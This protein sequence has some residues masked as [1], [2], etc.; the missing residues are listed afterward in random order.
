V[1]EAA[2][3]QTRMFVTLLQGRED[4][5]RSAAEE[6]AQLAA[7]IREGAEGALADA[8]LAMLEPG[9]EPARDALAAA[10]E[11][12]RLLDDK[13]ALAWVLNRGAQR[14]RLSGRPE[15][16]ARLAGEALEKAQ[17][18]EARSEAAIA[19]MSPE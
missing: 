4:E 10:A 14:E 15:A 12:L 1:L 11:R 18:V 2:A 8:V 17:L 6:L 7:R 3:V 5:A 19:A 13:R 16:A 9:P